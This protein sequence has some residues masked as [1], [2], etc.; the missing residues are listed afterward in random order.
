MSELKI[1]KEYK[2]EFPICWHPESIPAPGPGQMIGEC[3]IHNATC[4]IC[5]YGW[6]QD[7][8]CDCPERRY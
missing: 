7:P 3:P 1:E 4:P 5:G 6:G 8:S 2:V